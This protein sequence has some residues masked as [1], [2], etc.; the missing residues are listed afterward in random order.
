MKKVIVA[1][2]NIK[3]SGITAFLSLAE[4]VVASAN[5][6]TG[7]TCYKLLDAV[8]NKGEFFIYEEYINEAAIAAH[9]ASEHFKTFIDGI[10][11]LLSQAP[12][13]N[14]Y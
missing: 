6:E 5:N 9:N 4:E 3:E 7:C 8:A 2:L 13:I 10:S 1:Q 11:P 12:I 14:T